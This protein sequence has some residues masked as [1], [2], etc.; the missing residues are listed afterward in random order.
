MWGGA[1][2]ASRAVPARW[3]TPS[4]RSRP[5]ATVFLRGAPAALV[6]YSFGAWVALRVAAAAP[7]RVVAV[8]AVAPPFDFLDWD[9]LAAV[10]PRATLVVGERDQ[11][12]AP[13]RLARVR[14]AHGERIA[15]RTIP[16]ADHFFVGCEDEIAAAVLDALNALT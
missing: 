8:V 15:F 2:A 7:A 6:G 13:E 3:R 4:G 10:T 14:A 12:C 5:W 16:H 1:A 9:F 11:F